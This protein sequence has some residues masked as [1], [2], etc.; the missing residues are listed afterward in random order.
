VDEHSDIDSAEEAKNV[1]YFQVGIR[2]ILR[3]GINLSSNNDI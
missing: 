1:K 2:G 3:D